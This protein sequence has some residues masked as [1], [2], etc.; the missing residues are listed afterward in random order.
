MNNLDKL[1]IKGKRPLCGEVKVSGA[2]NATLPL[3]T[4]SLMINKGFE[5]TNVPNLLD[6]KIM[7]K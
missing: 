1:V 5:L 6:T 2:K 3:M 4:I 7:K